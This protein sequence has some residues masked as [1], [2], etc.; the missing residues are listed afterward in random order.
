[1]KQIIV[2]MVVVVL[3]GCEKLYLSKSLTDLKCDPIKWKPS[4][5]VFLPPL[6]EALLAYWRASKSA[7]R[8][9][10]AQVLAGYRVVTFRLPQKPPK[11]VKRCV[12][13]RFLCWRVR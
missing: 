11:H 5:I 13:A 4:V 9:K 3:V 8:L 10:A 1:M 6:R 2:M 7:G 12:L